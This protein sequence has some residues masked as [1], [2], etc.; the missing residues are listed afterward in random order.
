MKKQ[1]YSSA[2]PVFRN[3]RRQTEIDNGV[4]FRTMGMQRRERREF[5]GVNRSL[6]R[7][8]HEAG[9]LTCWAYPGREALPLYPD[10]V[11]RV[12]WHPGDFCEHRQK[13]NLCFELPLEGMLVIRERDSETIVTPGMVGIIHRGEDS[14]LDAG[15]EGFCRKLSFGLDGTALHV[16]VAA[17]GLSGKIAFPLPDPAAV[18]E[19]IG[20][21]ERGLR[22]KL[23]ES[24]SALCGIS[25]E[26]LTDFAFAAA[27]GRDER[28]VNALTILAVSIP[29]RITMADVAAKLGVTPMT[30]E[31][32]FRRH[33]DKSPKEYL[34][35]LRMQTASELLISTTLSVQEIAEKAG[36]GSPTAFSRLFRQSFA[37]SPREYRRKYAIR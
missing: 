37:L 13:Y 8:A 23:P 31:R 1:C 2:V 4:L 30:L 12:E 22:D 16:L 24:Y 33:L 32:L 18:Y 3:R 11:H 9:K 21:L 20:R 28:L 36:C 10:F 14:R 27:A 29:N 25:L 5:L 19:K 26:I 34:T 6:T 7:M 35:E 15:P 17:Y